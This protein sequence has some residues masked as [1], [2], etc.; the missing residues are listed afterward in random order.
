M[1]RFLEKKTVILF[2]QQGKALRGVQKNSCTPQP[3]VINILKVDSKI[4]IKIGFSYHL[5]IQ[6]Y[7]KFSHGICL[8]LETTML[9]DHLRWSDET[10][11][12]KER[13]NKVNVWYRQALNALAEGKAT[14][15]GK[16]INLANPKEVIAFLYVYQRDLAAF[17]EPL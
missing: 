12:G 8:R 13:M 14:F 9:E 4:N 11:E 10:L 15:L 3:I 6:S 2:L 1:G 7:I 16:P 5:G 17:H